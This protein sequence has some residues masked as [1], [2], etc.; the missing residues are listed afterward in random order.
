M[1]RAALF[2]LRAMDVML[3]AM[4][5]ARCV[6]FAPPGPKAA[7]TVRRIGE[8]RSSPTL[9]ITQALPGPTACANLITRN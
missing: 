3:P 2:G 8:L 4:A 7:H 9:T 1:T 6:T 5:E